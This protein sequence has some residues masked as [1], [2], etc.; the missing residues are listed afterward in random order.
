MND[1]REMILA[2]LLMFDQLAEQFGA[3][4]T[5]Y[6]DFD[7]LS[8]KIQ[9]YRDDFATSVKISEGDFVAYK[10]MVLNELGD[11]VDGE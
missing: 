6:P 9:D 8:R 7:D 11:A 4:S 3:L 2:A 10:R 1:K 5:V